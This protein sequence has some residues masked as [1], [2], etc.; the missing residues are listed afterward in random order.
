MPVLESRV[1]A[2]AGARPTASLQLPEHG[3]QLMRIFGKNTLWLLLDRAGLKMGAMLAGLVLVGYLGPT[4]L[5]VYST[6]IAVGTLLNALTDFGIT[7]Y[8]ARVVSAYPQEAPFILALSLTTTLAASLLEVAAIIIAYRTGH[9]YATCIFLGFLFTNLEGTSSICTMFLSAELRAR[10]VL[11][12]S[13]LSTV[14]VLTTIGLVL[15][16]HWSV[17]GLL[18]GLAAKSLIA[19]VFRIWQVR[20]FWPMA[21][22]YFLPSQFARIIKNSWHYFSYSVTQLGYEKVAIISFGLVA[23]H[24]EVGLFSAAIILAGIFPSFTYAASDALLPVMT[25]LYEAGRTADLLELRQRLMNLLL[26]MCVPVGIVLAIFA[27][28]ICH[29]LGS[30]YV[31]SAPILRVMASRSLLSVLDNFLGQSGLTAIARVRERRNAQATGLIVCAVLTI[32]MGLYWGAMGAAV[33]TLVADAIIIASYFRVY[34]RIGMAIE[35]PA[36]WSTAVAGVA[37][38]VACVAIPGV[39]AARALAAGGVYFM[40][41]A[42]IA[43]GRLIETAHTFRQSFIS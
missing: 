15:K 33:A 2:M 14:G 31:S 4:N 9:W 34:S 38:A 19:L 29:L 24:A 37:M 17:Q 16:F 7:R 5:G 1:P 25:R 36:A 21:W 12:G 22:S 6:A 32:V 30:K 18:I 41:F 39:W 20:K 42:V 13:I 3:H 40:V 27:P 23:T 26:V 11:P 35:C 28:E 8:A 43:R 10:S